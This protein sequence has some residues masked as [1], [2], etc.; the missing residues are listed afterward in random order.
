MRDS[1]PVAMQI[2]DQIGVAREPHQRK[3]LRI[4]FRGRHVRREGV[5][6]RGADQ[7]RVG[8]NVIAQA[9]LQ[10]ARQFRT[11]IGKAPVEVLPRRGLET[12]HLHAK[13]VLI[14]A[15][16]IRY[17][18]EHDPRAQLPRFVQF[19]ERLLEIPRGDKA[20]QF[21]G[22]KRCLNLDCG[23]RFVVRTEVI[24]L[25]CTA[26][27]RATRRR[28]YVDECSSSKISRQKTKGTASGAF[29]VDATLS[30][31]RR[32]LD[33][34]VSGEKYFAMVRLKVPFFLIS[35]NTLFRLI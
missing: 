27:F 21:I 17:R 33:R 14:H 35:T 6:Q 26:R 18:H 11:E 29:L 19:S 34:D 7:V 31:I 2:D 9:I 5:T 15:N 12:A 20:G 3:A 23:K 25:D 13:S 28:A 32:S 22:M 10:M 24:T 30:I 1:F 8:G 4:E 16:G